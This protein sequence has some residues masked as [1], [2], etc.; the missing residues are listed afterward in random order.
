[1][2]IKTKGRAEVVGG[3]DLPGQAM[4]GQGKV[5]W[6]E[7]FSRPS[8]RKM[9][10]GLLLNFREKRNFLGCCNKAKLDE[11]K[12]PKNN[13]EGVPIPRGGGGK[14]GKKR[15]PRMVRGGLISFFQTR[16]EI[17]EM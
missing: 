6:G 8:G 12:W 10:G 3:G 16:K 11:G 9:W 7:T 5:I 15:T 14:G 2:D 4:F 1:M 17:T 13:W